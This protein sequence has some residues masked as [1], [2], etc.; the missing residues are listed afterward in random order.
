MSMFAGLA[1]SPCVVS[2]DGVAQPVTGVT[3]KAVVPEA[4]PQPTVVPVA[5]PEPAPVVLTSTGPSVEDRVNHYEFRL[6]D[7]EVINKARELQA[8]GVTF[9]RWG[10]VIKQWVPRVWSFSLDDGDDSIYRRAGAAIVQSENSPTRELEQIEKL[11]KLL[12]VVAKIQHNRMINKGFWKADQEVT[13]E[14]ELAA[15]AKTHGE[16]SEAVE[17]IRLGN[18]CD[19]HIPSF[20]GAEAEFADTIIRLLDHAGAKGY[21][22]G[23]ALVAKMAY[24]LSRPAKH[25]KLA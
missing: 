20:L 4:T 17:A 2:V 8:H 14:M 22:I 23:E 24:N 6:S 7:T 15:I 19:D 25:G 5:V 3:L 13:I 9:E 16:L 18:C 10:S 1:V 21:R 11:G 12:D